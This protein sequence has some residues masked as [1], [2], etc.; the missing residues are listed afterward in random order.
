MEKENT[1]THTP[2]S[3]K[4]IHQSQV[5][6][7]PSSK[8]GN[9]KFPAPQSS[10]YLSLTEWFFPEKEAGAPDSLWVVLFSAVS[11]PLH[12]ASG[13]ASAA[14]VKRKK[15]PVLCGVMTL[16]FS[17]E[18]TWWT[19]DLLIRHDSGSCLLPFLWH[20]SPRLPT[21]FLFARFLAWQAQQ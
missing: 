18:L 4:L 14:L 16:E 6:P 20:S 21:C 12:G 9:T 5:R 8:E 2:P 10:M 1:H 3:T 19:F 11:F 13:W 15:C 17:R 7:T